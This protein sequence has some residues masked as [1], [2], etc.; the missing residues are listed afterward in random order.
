MENKIIHGDCAIFKNKIFEF[1]QDDSGFFELIDRGKNFEF[2]REMGFV[3]YNDSISYIKLKRENI[4]SAYK[5]RT[6]CIYNGWGY[7]IENIIY[8]KAI[9][10]PELETKSHLGL[11][12]YDDKRIE[13]EYNNFIEEVDEI[14]EERTPIK[15]F[16]FDVEPVHYIKKDGKYLE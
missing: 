15:G 5:V 13:V 10:G 14:W 12:V 4:E 8:G 9:L 11:H 7:E 2:L 1:Y 16:K 6:R 3:K